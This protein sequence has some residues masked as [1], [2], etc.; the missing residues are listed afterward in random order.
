MQFTLR[1]SL[2]QRAATL[3]HCVV[4]HFFPRLQAGLQT[5]EGSLALL[6]SVM[7]PAV[8]RPL[9]VAGA[10]A[11]LGQEDML[12]ISRTPAAQR[13]Q[14]DGSIDSQFS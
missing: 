4:V 5:Q 7:S 2:I 13:R 9:T 1:M 12:C 8:K 3:G 11:Q 14:Q 10:L 6:V